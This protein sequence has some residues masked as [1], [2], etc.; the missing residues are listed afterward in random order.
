MKKGR[1]ER[2]GRSDNESEGCSKHS[3]QRTFPYSVY[4]KRAVRSVKYCEVVTY[5]VQL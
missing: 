3:R 1:D 4:E 2:D 5:L